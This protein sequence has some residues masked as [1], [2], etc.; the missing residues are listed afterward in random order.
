MRW[1]FLLIFFVYLYLEIS[2]FVA[3]AN[4]VGV[5]LALIGIIA[6]SVIGLSLVKSQGLKNL[7]LMQHKM[8]NN[9]NPNHELVRSVSLL[10]AGFLLFIPGFLTDI[11]GALILL[12]PVQRLLVK[13]VVPKAN[14]KTYH[15]HSNQNASSR[16]NDVIEGT[17][18]QKDDE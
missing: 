7:T 13:H 11:I 10:F 8:S 4:T 15:N 16:N 14:I 2:V 6:T 3:V 18:K 9:E 12:S 17:F 1:R 5:L